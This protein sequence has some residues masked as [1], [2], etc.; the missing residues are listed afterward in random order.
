MKKRFLQTFF[1]IF[2]KTEKNDTY[3]I[4]H[5]CEIDD[6]RR[7]SSSRVVRDA[8]DT[9]SA[10]AISFFVARDMGWYTTAR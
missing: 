7:N 4:P 3:Q 9:S 1:D 2:H 6:F 8:C 10:P 5:G